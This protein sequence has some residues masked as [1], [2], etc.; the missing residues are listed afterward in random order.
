MRRLLFAIVGISVVL[1]AKPAPST[2]PVYDS[3]LS[4]TAT[5][6][7]NIG[8]TAI[9]KAGVVGT[10][11]DA[12]YGLRVE[13][14]DIQKID[15][16]IALHARAWKG[17]KPVG[18]GADGT[19]EIEKFVVINP[20]ILID[21]PTGDITRTSSLTGIVRRLRE[22]L[23]LATYTSLAHTMTT[24]AKDG[25]TIIPGKIG[26]TTT[27]AYPDP[28]PESVSVDGSTR[29]L[30]ADTF[31]NLRA[32]AGTSASDA[33]TEQTATRF[34][35]TTTS[36]QFDIIDRAVQ[37]FDTSSIPDTDVISS[38]TLSFKRGDPTVDSFSQSLVIDRNPPAS[39]TALVSGD[40]NVAGWDGVEQASN[41]I[42]AAD[43]SVIDYNDF[44]LNATGQANISQT[45][46]SW[47]GT[48]GSSD[49]DNSAPTWES[50]TDSYIS[51]AAAETATTA[52]DPKLVVEHAEA[53]ASTPYAPPT[54]VGPWWF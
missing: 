46:I 51:F 5:E 24:V 13:I 44:T 54:F 20:P 19:V 30:A 47:F 50:G 29:R 32:G 22:D 52:S 16:G 6:K 34:R 41:R 43:W 48:R 25:S 36:D 11:D 28:D 2:H 31:A 8:A 15:R 12:T 45:G 38:A 49:F 40:F 1:A 10:Y 33:S 7:A 26:N 18:F 27:T 37:G 4:K 17:G 21:D 9:T 3:I 35:S 14:L 42:T 39:A 23:V 53:A